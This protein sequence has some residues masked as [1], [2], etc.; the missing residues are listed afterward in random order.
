MGAGGIDPHIGCLSYGTTATINTATKKYVEKVLATQLKFEDRLAN[1]N[2]L[3]IANVNSF[4]HIEV[5]FSNELIN[6]LQK[7]RVHNATRGGKNTNYI[8]NKFYL[9]HDPSNE[10]TYKEKK[11]L[12]WESVFN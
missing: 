10:I 3:T 12:E 8:N 7:L 2:N 9:S 11:V 5:E 6:N 4:K 1:E